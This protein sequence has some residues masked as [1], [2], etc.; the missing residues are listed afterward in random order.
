[1]LAAELA[2][3]L[4]GLGILCANSAIR[5]RVFRARQAAPCNQMPDPIAARIPWYALP[6]SITATVLLL[7]SVVL[8]VP[9]FRRAYRRGSHGLLALS[10]V[11][12]AVALLATVFTL[13]F[14][15]YG[16]VAETPITPRH[17]E[18]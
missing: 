14:G 7:V 16:I 13:W 12:L 15:V 2:A 8:G 1:L 10:L 18:G 11:L 5:E 3:F 4:L 9:A 17:C 6:L